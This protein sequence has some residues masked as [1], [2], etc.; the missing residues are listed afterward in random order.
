[1]KQTVAPCPYHLMYVFDTTPNKVV[2]DMAQFEAP[3]CVNRSDFKKRV[4]PT[5]TSVK[6]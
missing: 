6:N 5:F 3:F 4:N 1:M 2:M